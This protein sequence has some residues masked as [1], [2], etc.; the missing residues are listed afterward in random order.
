M[1]QVSYHLNSIAT[2]CSWDENIGFLV[3]AGDQ[4]CDLFSSSTRTIIMQSTACNVQQIGNG[5]D[6]W[7]LSFSCIVFAPWRFPFSYLSNEMEFVDEISRDLAHN[8]TFSFA[9]FQKMWELLHMFLP[10]L[11]HFQVFAH[12]Q[13]MFFF[14]AGLPHD[15]PKIQPSLRFFCR[16]DGPY[17]TSTGPQAN[18]PIMMMVGSKIKIMI[19]SGPSLCS[20]SAFIQIEYEYTSPEAHHG[21]DRR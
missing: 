6:W 12:L 4:S 16:P 9:I 7:W 13:P 21:L 19:H 5:K 2:K 15:P 20:A 11:Y 17:N 18:K 3:Y 8:F 1:H 14:S 10:N